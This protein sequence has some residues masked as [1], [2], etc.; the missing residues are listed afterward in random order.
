MLTS[1]GYIIQ[2]P[3]ICFQSFSQPLLSTYCMPS[4]E[5]GAGVQRLFFQDL[6]V[7]VELRRER[8][9]QTANEMKC[10]EV[11]W[12]HNKSDR[13]SSGK[14]LPDQL[15]LMWAVL[16][17]GD[18][19][20]AGNCRVRRCL[21]EAKGILNSPEQAVTGAW[22]G[23]MCLENGRSSKHRLVEECFRRQGRKSWLMFWRASATRPAGSN[24]TSTAVWLP[25]HSPG[26]H[27]HMMIW[28][29]FFSKGTGAAPRPRMP[30][31]GTQSSLPFFPKYLR[32]ITLSFPIMCSYR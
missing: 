18:D 26:R 4:P 11:P 10:K 17:R 20:W 27:S 22:K 2:N 6:P 19:V 9:L 30:A 12:R 5:L 8:C 21:L 7:H 25:D 16:P 23:Q 29:P 24:P 31:E 1:S 13:E 32:L 14:G 3:L 28:C 15:I